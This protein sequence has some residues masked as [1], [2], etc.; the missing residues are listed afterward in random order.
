M[1]GYYDHETKMVPKPTI[2]RDGKRKVGTPIRVSPLMT[3]AMSYTMFFAAAAHKF[4]DTNLSQ[5]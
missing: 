1:A 4:T 3:R 5:Y 2:V